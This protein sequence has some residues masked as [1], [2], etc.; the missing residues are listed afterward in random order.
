MY[1]FKVGYLNL[2]SYVPSASKF[3]FGQSRAMWINKG[4]DDYETD[5]YLN[6]ILA[7]N[8]SLGKELVPK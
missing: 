4:T 3:R 7:Q 1:Y 6:F 8:T 2:C 5:S